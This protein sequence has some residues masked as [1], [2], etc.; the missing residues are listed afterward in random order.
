MLGN[1]GGHLLNYASSSPPVTGALGVIGLSGRA[2]NDTY[3]P[4]AKVINECFQLP[5][6]KK[7]VLNQS[8]PFLFGTTAD[9]MMKLV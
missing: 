5:I 8:P 9:H 1:G 6:P 4:E 7:T 2:L 3:H